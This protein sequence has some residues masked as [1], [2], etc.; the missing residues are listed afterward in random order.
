M[1]LLGGRGGG[2]L[3]LVW[4]K[5]NSPSEYVC[6]DG[7]LVSLLMLCSPW[8]G[9]YPGAEV[10]GGGGGRYVG[11]GVVKGRGVVT[12]VDGKAVED[13]TLVG[14]LLLSGGR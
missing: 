6:G 14:W 12:K 9:R 2:G 4:S 7:S 11:L 10:D 8:G 3:V 13:T 5:I 1:N